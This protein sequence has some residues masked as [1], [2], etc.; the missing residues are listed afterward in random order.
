[1]KKSIALILSIFIA[2][3]AGTLGSIFTSPNIEGWYAELTKPSWNPPAWVFAPVWITLFTLMGIAAFFI[4]QEKHTVVRVA[5]LRFYIIQL[6]LNASWS[7]LFFG[8]HRP[9]LAF[10]EILILWAFILIT[11]LYFWK[12]RPLAGYL[13]IPYLA[14]VSFAAVLNATIWYLN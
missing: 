8:M 9:D 10:I 6:V 13:M 2:Q 5:A 7:F 3:M 4:W 1:M 14:W 12:L 11:L